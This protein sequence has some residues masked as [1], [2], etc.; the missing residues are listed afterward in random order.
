RRPPR[1]TLFPYTTL[2]RSRTARDLKQGIRQH[3]I[4]QNTNIMSA[5][6]PSTEA[7]HV[8]QAPNILLNQSDNN[9]PNSGGP[10]FSFISLRNL[11][12]LFIAIVKFPS[13]AVLLGMKVQQYLPILAQTPP[14]FANI[15]SSTILFCMVILEVASNCS[16]SAFNASDEIGR[17]SCRER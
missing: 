16:P 14:S 4:K 5:M 3:T 9:E 13:G 1:S 11:N 7:N 12:S 6:M 15:Q 10:A 17:A 8:P 2:F